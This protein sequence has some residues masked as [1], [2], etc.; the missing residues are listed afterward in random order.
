VSLRTKRQI[1]A[2][3]KG[4]EV[5]RQ[6]DRLVDLALG[7]SAI[8]PNAQSDQNVRALTPAILANIQSRVSERTARHWAQAIVLAE[9]NEDG[10]EELARMVADRELEAERLK[11]ILVGFDTSIDPRM[12]DIVGEVQ[13]IVRD[14]RLDVQPDTPEWAVLSRAVREGL[15]KGQ[16]EIDAMLS[17]AAS[18]VPEER[19]K[20][21][22]SA[23]PRLSEAVKD[24]IAQPKAPRTLREVQTSLASFIHAVGDLRINEITRTEVMQFCKIEGSKTVG[25]K[26]KGSIER[27]ISPATL[28]KKITL[29]GSAINHAIETEA[30]HGPNPFHKINVK[31]FTQPVPKAIMPN[32]R[33]F[34]PHELQL[35]VHHP[36]F[37]GCAS[38]TNTHHPG[39]FRLDGMHYWVPILAM[40]SGCRAGEI[41]G[42]RVTEVRL[43]YRHPHIVIQDNAW[44]TTKGGYRRL[45]PLLDVL[46]AHGFGNYVER[47]A[48][49]GHDRL[50]PDWT[51]PANRTDAGAPAWSNGKLIRAF[52]R[53]VVP[54]QLRAILAEGATLA[55]L[56][57][58]RR[59][60]RA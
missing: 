26:S 24:Y 30:F 51:P 48:S 40:H 5:E 16:R 22:D 28:Q 52:N 9:L 1:E 50:F 45:V 7:R 53:T 58:I 41:G 29:I 25:G 56:T 32:K 57:A 18:A 3:Q 60:C 46:I 54:Q 23:A 33:P 49:A 59:L 55:D 10:R 34:S 39:S 44:R 13:R 37:T 4:A 31:R 17:G 38:Q 36:W 2:M 11:D 27:P 14:Q 21:K 12:P 19:L 35:I 15:I 47:I 43:D 20:P 42:L 8:S 6:F